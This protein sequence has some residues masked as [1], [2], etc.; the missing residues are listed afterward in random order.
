M[1]IIMKVTVIELS[2]KWIAIKYNEN[3]VYLIDDKG[4][5]IS[6]EDTITIPWFMREQIKVLL[7]K[8]KRMRIIKKIP[9]IEAITDNQL[10]TIN[11]KIAWKLHYYYGTSRGKQLYQFFRNL[12]NSSS[13]K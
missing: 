7:R 11:Q 9:R 10:S 12:I 8:L 5:Y 2:D 13:S 1:V 4:T 3:M 6:I